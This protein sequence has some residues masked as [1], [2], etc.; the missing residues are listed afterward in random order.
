MRKEINLF[1]AGI[2]LGMLI[3]GAFEGVAGYMLLMWMGVAGINIA[4]YFS[5]SE[6]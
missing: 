1:F 2:F 4:A 3:V 5:S 6:E